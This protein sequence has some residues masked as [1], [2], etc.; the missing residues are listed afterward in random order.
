MTVCLRWCRVV[1]VPLRPHWNCM[2]SYEGWEQ[3]EQSAKS[4][5]Q[6]GSREAAQPESPPRPKPKWGYLADACGVVKRSA[7]L[8]VYTWLMN[9]LRLELLMTSCWL[10]IWKSKSPYQLMRNRHTILEIGWLGA[11]H[12]IETWKPLNFVLQIMSLLIAFDCIWLHLI[13]LSSPCL[14]LLC[15]SIWFWE[16]HPASLDPRLDAWTGQGPHGVQC[17]QGPL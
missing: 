13:A 1:S 3:W 6:D 15:L 11:V 12:Q 5:L 16:G 4:E 17:L 7:N 9:R 8:L 14:S 10:E 2:F